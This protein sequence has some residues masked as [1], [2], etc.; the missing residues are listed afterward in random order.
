MTRRKRGTRSVY[1]KRYAEIIC[2][3]HLMA[4]E[5]STSVETLSLKEDFGKLGLFASTAY[6]LRIMHQIRNAGDEREI[7][8]QV[9][10]LARTCLTTLSWYENVSCEKLV[11]SQYELFLLKNKRY[12]SSFQECY[13]KDGYH[14][15]FGHLQEKIN[16]I[17]SLLMLN[18]E[19][20]EEPL[21][22]SL[23]D[24]LGYCVLT[25]I[26]LEKWN[27]EQPQKPRC[28]TLSK[29]SKGLGTSKP[30]SPKKNKNFQLHL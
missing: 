5:S 27:K 17:C 2:G 9:Y 13:A 3:I 22:D 15:A 25:L 18:D 23:K 29:E 14:Y 19:A 10:R 6:L 16:R 26:E 24:L 20:S 4:A 12:G 28:E 11:S 30:S 21:T 7:R 8:T 1:S